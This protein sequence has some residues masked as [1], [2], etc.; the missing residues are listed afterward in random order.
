MGSGATK[1][2][3]GN[4]D[5]AD[6]GQ[7]AMDMLEKLTRETEDLKSLVRS[8]R[9]GEAPKGG[10]GNGSLKPP[11]RVALLTAG[12]L[13]PCLASAAGG[14]IARYTEVYPSVSIIAYVGGYKGLLAGH[15]LE[16]TPDVRKCAA[17]LH[18]VGGSPIGNSRVK[19]TNIKDCVKR[20][21]V[22][23]GQ[24]PQQVAADQLVKDGVDILHTIGGDDTNLAAAELAFFLKKND[25]DLTVIGLPKTIDNDVYPIKQTLGAWTA[26]EEGAKFFSN[27]VNEQSASHRMLIIHEVMGRDCGYLTAATART[28]RESLKSRPMVP[29]LGLHFEKMDI[30]AVFIPEIPIDIE[31]EAVRLSKVMDACGTVNIFISEGAGVKDIV[32]EMESRGQAL[33]RD[34]FGHIKLNEVNPGQ[35]FANRFGELVKSSKTMVV[36]SGYFSRA[37]PANQS[38]IDLIKSCT[39]LA[40]ELAIQRVGGVIG[41]DENA[42]GKLRGCEFERVKGGK[43]FDVS[44]GWFREMMAEITSPVRLEV[45]KVTFPVLDGYVPPVTPGVTLPKKVALL[46][47]GGL[48]PCVAASVGSII[49]RYTELYPTVEILCYKSGFRGL[50]A[51]ESFLVSAEARRDAGLLCMHGGSPLGA[52]RI[53]LIETSMCVSKGLIKEGQDPVAVAAEQLAKDGVEVLHTIGGD[54][55]NRELTKYLKANGSPIRILSIAKTIDN[56]VTPVKQSCGAWSA[57]EAG[58]KFFNNVVTESS[59]NPR[60]VIVHEV[61]GENCGYL[62]ALT[63]DIYRKMVASRSYCDGIGLSKGRYDVHAIFVPEVAIDIQAEAARLKDLMAVNDCVNIFLSEGA[64]IESIAADME[65]KGQTVARDDQGKV[66]AGE[67]VPSEWFSKTFSAMLGAEKVLVQKSGYYARTTVANSEDLRLIK[68]C[69][70]HLVECA[71]RG[72]SGLVAHDEGNYNVLRAIEF[73][74][75]KGYKPFDPLTPWFQQMLAGIGQKMEYGAGARRVMDVSADAISD[76]KVR[77][78]IVKRNDAF[79][80]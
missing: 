2:T 31:A 60:M 75:V 74:R 54:E 46:T 64:G 24:D 50:L 17:D 79:F 42:G 26:A 27:V 10:L 61:M 4:V 36:K 57:A 21:L 13:A 63:A 67:I 32:K 1:G 53:K 34:A 70:D 62:T 51:G 78:N 40:V 77:V 8:V 12:G 38:D 56:D 41:H 72:E 59:A 7:K 19:L 3:N 6:E 47:A 44:Q 28:Y 33:P 48:S 68:S 14:L 37:A 55:S 43:P 16:V 65:R 30:H 71:I 22:K 11:G 5:V 35:W 66:K 20:G 58:A 39:D 49:E 23:E 25:Y 15:Y 9:G 69:T 80:R 18:L 45:P 52:S 76:M 29:S 73:D